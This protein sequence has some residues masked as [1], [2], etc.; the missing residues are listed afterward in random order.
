MTDTSWVAAA[1]AQTVPW[2]RTAGITFGEVTAE[3][4]ECRLPDSP[5]LH[6][7]VGGPHAAMIFGLGETASGAVGLAAFSS[8]MDRVTPL[9]VRSEISYSRL[10][11]GP[12]DAVAVL[13]RPAAEVLAELDGGTRP[14][15]TVSV[16]ITDAEG[17][18]TTSMT[19]VWTLR[20]NR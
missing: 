3:R 6:N 15:F 13:D 7:H 16:T 5:D 10:A 12:I 2:V 1:M 14:E 4:V 11:R 9:V 17:R 8:A 18:E 20:P 19:V